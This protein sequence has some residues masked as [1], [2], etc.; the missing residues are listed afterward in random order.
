MYQNTNGHV[1]ENGH[2]VE[3]GLSIGN[4]TKQSGF[5]NPKIEVNAVQEIALSYRTILQ[6]IGED[7]S[8]EGL[9]KTPE[10]AAKALLYFTKGY[11]ENLLGKYYEKAE[12]DLLKKLSRRKFHKL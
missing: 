8:R 11:T 10:R 1:V 12:I 3:N 9:L 4:G 2:A 5:K 6:S 7:P